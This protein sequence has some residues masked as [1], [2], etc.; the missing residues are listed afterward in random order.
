MIVFEL[1]PSIIKVVL[2]STS[3]WY[4]NGAVTGFGITD[5]TMEGKVGFTL[6]MKIRGAPT[7][8]ASSTT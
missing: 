7:G 5:L 8:P 4:G 6:D 3:N 2:A 1:C